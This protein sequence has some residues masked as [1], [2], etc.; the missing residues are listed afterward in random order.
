MKKF[1]INRRWKKK[2][3][4]LTGCIILFVFSLNLAG[5]TF[6]NQKDYGNFQKESESLSLQEE[7][8][9]NLMESAIE[10]FLNSVEESDFQETSEVSIETKET[11]IPKE[12]IIEL[13]PGHGGRQSGA[14]NESHNVLEKDINLKIARYL[15]EELETYEHVTVYLTR[16]D[17]TEV[18]L[19]DRI[20]KAIEDN[21]SIIISLHNNAVGPMA[22]YDHGSTVLT[23]RGA[24]R[25]KVSETGQEIGCYILN[26]L[27]EIGLEN[28]GLMFRICQNET[29]YPNGELCDYYSI[30]RNAVKAGIPGII[31]EHSF[32]DNENDYENYLSD[33]SKLKTLAQADA[34]GI[35]AYYGLISKV[36]GKRLEQLQNYEEKITVIKS[37]D[38]KDNQYLTK[39]YFTN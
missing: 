35:A 37:D 6:V 1:S 4:V 24:Y 30:I 18:E 8:T 32:L 19:E 13:D 33:D 38:N 29:T 39:T 28:Q 11:E 5:C 7:E 20:V 17:D 27:S 10:S 25:K 21:A 34:K 16:E 14:V 26:A 12:V 15:K 22:D 31:V 23:P 36:T 9:D 3:T 2:F